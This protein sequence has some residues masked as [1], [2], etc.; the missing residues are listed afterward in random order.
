MAYVR[1]YCDVGSVEFRHIIDATQLLKMH[2]KGLPYTWT[3]GKTGY[4][5]CESRLDR[6]FINQAWRDMWLSMV[7]N[8]YEGGTSDQ[9]ALEIRLHQIA[10]PRRPFPLLN[11]WMDEVSY[12][13]LVRM[14][15]CRYYMLIY[16]QI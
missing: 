16:L 12:N 8:I 7:C 2:K 10:K 5:R 6:D 1:E 11:S 15:E 9:F 4:S 13:D 14:L 3:N